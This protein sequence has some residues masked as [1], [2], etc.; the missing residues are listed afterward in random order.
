MRERMD[1]L[2]QAPTTSISSRF[3]TKTSG[4]NSGD[5]NSSSNDVA[6]AR[7][8]INRL[9]ARETINTSIL[10]TPMES[11]VAPS[12]AAQTSLQLATIPK[13]MTA[14]ERARAQ[15]QSAAH[16]VNFKNDI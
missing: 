15:H 11:L 5:L 2:L 3:E 8:M 16:H 9:Q 14:A 12:H 4:S 1:S 7:D 10:K 13:I 6:L